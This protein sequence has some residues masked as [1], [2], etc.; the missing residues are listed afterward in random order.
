MRGAFNSVKWKLVFSLLLMGMFCSSLFS[1]QYFVDIVNAKTPET[2]GNLLITFTGEGE[3]SE[4]TP[5]NGWWLA[6]ANEGPVFPSNPDSPKESWQFLLNTLKFDFSKFPEI[7]IRDCELTMNALSRGSHYLVE[8]DQKSK[9]NG[10]NATFVIINGIFTLEQVELGD[11]FVYLDFSENPRWSAIF[12]KAKI[13]D[14][15]GVVSEI[16]DNSKFFI[17]N[18]GYRSSKYVVYNEFFE[19][20]L[21]EMNSQLQLGKIQI[22]LS[23]PEIDQEITIDIIAQSYDGDKE[24]VIAKDLSRDTIL[25][26]PDL[27]YYHIEARV[28]TKSD[29]ITERKSI[30]ALYN[31]NNNNSNGVLSYFYNGDE[32]FAPIENN[33]VFLPYDYYN[34]Q[35]LAFIDYLSNKKEKVVFVGNNL[36]IMDYT[37]I[38]IV[39]LNSTGEGTNEKSTPEFL[40]FLADL[41]EASKRENFLLYQYLCIYPSTENFFV[42]YNI[43]E[44]KL[45]EGTD[46]Y[47]KLNSKYHVINNNNYNDFK[48]HISKGNVKIESEQKLKTFFAL[49]PFVRRP[50]IIQRTDVIEQI[51]RADYEKVSK[52]LYSQDLSDSGFNIK[53]V[54]FITYY[55]KEKNKESTV[56]GNVRYQYMD[57]LELKDLIF[58]EIKNF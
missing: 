47:K 37:N 56:T 30:R 44:V 9:V 19:K 26:I 35:N 13:K 51:N 1:T 32:M 28:L 17:K 33:R 2:K 53:N 49:E 57:Y 41:I 20:D 52:W 42:R 43:K 14:Q 22:D 54:V 21:H 16:V 15:E 48:M 24:I 6:E 50:K 10:N 45:F 27:D 31:W 11:Y 12:N 8:F 58:E 55:P 25:D 36:Q 46:V 29:L 38:V 39:D 7:N 40:D 4:I 3:L 18:Y 5:P 34:V 23:Y